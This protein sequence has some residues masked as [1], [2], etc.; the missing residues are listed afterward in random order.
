MI[1]VLFGYRARR[2]KL[3]PLFNVSTIH[4]KKLI[5][6]VAMVSLM[7][8]CDKKDDPTPQTPGQLLI[9]TWVLQ[10]LTSTDPD[11]QT[12]G[13]MLLG[14][15]WTFRVDKTHELQSSVGGFE[16]TFS[17]TWSMSDDGKTLTVSTDYDGTPVTSNMTVKVL[18]AT[19]LQLEET[20]SGMT[21]TFSFSPKP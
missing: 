18:S 11:Y 3:C 5:L 17:G 9:R 13:Q 6:I 15:S 21:T 12:S 2:R 10:S 1:L 8:A 20:E 19:E 14:S 4:M 7:A 16:L